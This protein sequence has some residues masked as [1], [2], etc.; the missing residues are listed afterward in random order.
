VDEGDDARC[1]LRVGRQ[2]R[3]QPYE[4]ATV[5]GRVG[6][7][8][9]PGVQHR[10][11]TDPSGGAAD[12][13]TLAIAHAE[14]RQGTHVAV[15]DF[16]AER[17]PPFSPDSVTAEY[18]QVLKSYA[19]KKVQAD[20]YAGAWVVEAFGKH[21]ITCVQSAEPKSDL[22]GNLLPLLNSGR[23]ELLDHPRL[24]AQ[25]LA[26]ERKTARGG[27]DSIDHPPS[28]HDDLANAVAG[29]LVA[30]VG[31]AEPGGIAWMRMI[32]ER[33]QAGAKNPWAW[34][35]DEPPAGPRA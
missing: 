16:V 33:H 19:I 27:K 34:W 13:F 1:E 28:G 18:A 21:G 6:L 30:T 4:A 17:R 31:A 15:L 20:K 9:L 12:A 10:G 29:A 2:A 24:Q 8:P 22:Y 32:Y 23:V 11:F 5:P 3:Q 26:L 35:E 14:E 25:L 7:P